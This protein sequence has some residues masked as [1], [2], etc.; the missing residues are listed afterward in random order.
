MELH[1][2]AELG[3]NEIINANIY[4]ALTMRQTQQTTVDPGAAHG[5]VKLM[6]PAVENSYIT[7]NSLKT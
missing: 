2:T 3:E 6:P 5:F 4:Q 1:W 7:F